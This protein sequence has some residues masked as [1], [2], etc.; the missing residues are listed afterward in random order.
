MRSSEV[1]GTLGVNRKAGNNFI[2]I[3]GFFNSV[4]IIN[5]DDRY[6]VKY[7]APVDSTVFSIKN[8]AGIA[9]GYSFFKT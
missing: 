5:D 6:T 9:A 4:K 2:D 7:I 1:L 3:H 8:F